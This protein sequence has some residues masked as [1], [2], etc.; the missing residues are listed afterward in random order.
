MSKEI[1]FKLT[2]GQVDKAT[3]PNRG[4]FD[5]QTGTAAAD[6]LIAELSAKYGKELDNRPTIVVGFENES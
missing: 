2:H 4:S 1:H 3:A 6:K 5:F